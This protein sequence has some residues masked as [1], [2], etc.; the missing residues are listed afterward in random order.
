MTLKASFVWRNPDRTSDLND[1]TRQ[2]V[3]RGVYW[4]G[5]VVPGAGLTVVVSPFI[6]M[7]YDGMTITSDASQILTVVDNQTNVCFVKAKY[8]ALGSPAVA[9]LQFGVLEES[10]FNADPEKDYYIVLCKVAVP[11]AAVSVVSANISFVERDEIDP[12]RRSLFRG[13][14]PNAAALPVPPSPTNRTGDFYFVDADSTFYFWDGVAWNALNTGSFNS[15]VSLYNDT[16]VQEE[17][18][19]HVEGS[20][21][22][23]GDRWTV[24]K[25]LSSTLEIGIIEEPNIADRIAFDAFTAYVNGLYVQVHAQ[26]ISMAAKG[27]RYDLIFLEVWREQVVS[28][29]TFPYP[30]NP[31]GAATYDIDQVD[32]QGAT[33]AWTPGLAGNNFDLPEIEARSHDWVVTKYRLAT[34]ENVTTAALYA[35]GSNA[36]ASLALNVDGV[37]FSTPAGGGTDPRV[38]MAT[39]GVTPIDGKSWAIPLFVVHRTTAEDFTINNAIRVF[40]GETRFVFPVYPVADMANTARGLVETQFRLTP[41]T[42]THDTSTGDLPSGFISHVR[43]FPIQASA[44]ANSIAL[45]P[46]GERL[47]IRMRGLE[48]WIDPAVEVDLGAPPGA[49]YERVFVYLKMN[50]TLYADEVTVPGST[51]P[52]R[53]VSERHRPYVPSDRVHPALPPNVSDQGWKRGYVTYEVVVENLGGVDIRDTDAAFT[54]SGWLHGDAS[55][56]PDTY[57]DGG[58]W[59]RALSIDAD[60]RI[61]PLLHEWAMPICL[62]HRRNT[63]AWSYAGNPNGSTASRVDDRTAAT[64]IHP[65][66]LVD[67]RQLADENVTWQEILDESIDRMMRGQLRTRMANKWAGPGSGGTVAGSRIL[68][69]DHV[70]T[71]SPGS[72]FALPDGDNMRRI[73]SDAREFHVVA[74]SFDVTLNYADVENLVDYNAGTKLLIIR[75]PAGAHLLRALPSTMMLD[76]NSASVNYMDFKGPPL[77]STRKDHATTPSFV[78]GTVVNLTTGVV[79]GIH[80]IYEEWTVTASD[81][82]GRA[83]EMQLT[84]T[85]ASG[86]ACLAWWVHYDRSITPP[87]N[88]NYGLAEIPDR[89]WS[90]QR[91]HIGGPAVD[92]NIGTLYTIVRKTLAASASIV[93]T[94]ADVQAASGVSGTT[95]TL[96][97]P[98]IDRL[99]FSTTAGIVSSTV[100]TDARDQITITLTAPYTGDVDVMVFFRTDDVDQWIEVGRGAKSVRAFFTWHEEALDTATD[101]INPTAIVLS[102]DIWQDAEVPGGMV[103]MPLVWRRNV[104]ATDWTLQT[105]FVAAEYRYSNLISVD[106]SAVADQYALVIAPKHVTPTASITDEF[107]V[108]YTYTPYQGLSSDGGVAAVPGTAVP[109]MKGMLH[110]VVIDNSDFFATQSGPTS[111]F[112]GVDSYTGY[113]V[114]VPHGNT[115][116]TFF[117]DGRFADYNDTALVKPAVAGTQDLIALK[118]ENGGTNAAALLRLPF[119]DNT[120]M[121]HGSYHAVPM[122]FDLDPGREG[123]STGYWSYAPAYMNTY[124]TILSGFAK[125]KMNQ[126]INGLTR[127]VDRGEAHQQRESTYVDPAN[128]FTIQL[129]A[130]LSTS[131]DGSW[132]LVGGLAHGAFKHHFPVRDFDQANLLLMS[133]SIDKTPA[134]WGVSMRDKVSGATVNVPPVGNLYDYLVSGGTSLENTSHVTLVPGATSD[135]ILA[136]CPG[137]LL[138]YERHRTYGLYAPSIFLDQLLDVASAD[139]HI[140]GTMVYAESKPSNYYSNGLFPYVQ[141]LEETAPFI[142]ILWLPFSSSS[143]LSRIDRNQ[144]GQRRGHAFG[145]S[146]LRGHLTGYPPSWGASTITNVETLI[147]AATHSRRGLYLGSSSTRYNM[148]LFVPGSGTELDLVLGL[149]DVQVEATATPPE[150]VPYMPGE[151]I[152]ATSNRQ[153]HQLDHG[154]PLAYVGFGALID[155]GSD[156]YRHRAVLQVSGG[157]TGPEAVDWPT[158]TEFTPNNLNG[159][160]ID[161]FWPL[162]RPVIKNT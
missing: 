21:I 52:Y 71:T 104:P 58:L 63:G 79:A 150:R 70:S 135:I 155:P 126:W 98:A 160:A 119:P 64:I 133:V 91:N 97:G 47:H 80:N 137:S 75:A 142:D 103:E 143:R 45:K 112:G 49:G 101:P 61:H 138:A 31:N 94:D 148:P 87:F 115:L 106:I 128:Y 149:E 144:Q 39:S 83:T 114:R 109:I 134:S 57:H 127:L 32:T 2:L 105:G 20:G 118:A 156:G 95:F 37:A 129:A 59:S 132:D 51:A 60:D 159:T 72:A 145:H 41:G 22:I 74:R 1:R 34:V 117:G 77:W 140:Y 29:Q 121:I 107:I 53:W 46:T 67:L 152:F 36:V 162:Y 151:S 131:N 24:G 12:L 116:Y 147:S 158:A 55:F 15:E 113:P 141:A 136:A 40:R 44:S 130:T 62:V 23:S 110:G 50:I 38:W 153:Y 73:W 86:T 123:A 139:N 25:D 30:R 82:I 56:T 9:P 146:S 4:G 111:F 7:S 3:Q 13:T 68:Q 48:D 157:P 96:C 28:P 92:L 108:H 43:S 14:V 19:R 76:G 33:V 154:G 16:L 122:A 8:N 89:V 99:R 65:D 54:A 88:A 17:L 120:L 42:T 10:V 5:G 100:M 18:R 85:A 125:V 69:S 66:D 161:A 81:A 11:P 27:N 93:I 26:E 124:T 78:R 6:A 102:N 35:P 84:I 90:A